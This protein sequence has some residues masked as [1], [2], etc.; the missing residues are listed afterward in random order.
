MKNDENNDLGTIK[1][2]DID[3]ESGKM[4]KI[5][6]T[7]GESIP[8]YTAIEQVPNTFDT[9]MDDEMKSIINGTYQEE[10]KKLEEQTQIRA[11]KQS[12]LQGKLIVA[13]IVFILVFTI[14]FISYSSLS[15]AYNARIIKE[16]T[17]FLTNNANYAN[18]IKNYYK[19]LASN[20]ENYYSE[21]IAETS[22]KNKAKTTKETLEK[23]LQNLE[24]KKED[25][26]KYNA[27]TL[28]GVIYGRLNEVLNLTKTQINGGN[29]IDIAKK[30]N[31]FIINENDNSIK[32]EEILKKY[33]KDNTIP[34]REESGRIVYDNEA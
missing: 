28:Y 25:F 29:A 27:S 19:T 13:A 24:K 21:S 22:M 7:Q 3:P 16:K 23:E 31:E 4:S 11:E 12:L 34:Y 9:P 20:A 33:L 5:D 6:G 8:E 18:D 10:Q 15:S 26:D 2:L 14:G 32:Y 1:F 17:I 30:T